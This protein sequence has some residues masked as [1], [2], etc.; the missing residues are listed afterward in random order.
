MAVDSGYGTVAIPLDDVVHALGSFDFTR[1][2]GAIKRLSVE[3][4]CYDVPL[5]PRGTVKMVDRSAV[6]TLLEDEG[7][8]A[9]RAFVDWLDTEFPQPTPLSEDDLLMKEARVVA[10]LMIDDGAT[11]DLVVEDLQIPS[12]RARAVAARATILYDQMHAK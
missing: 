2:W 11:A 9:A 4:A 12:K 5:L 8:P 6:V 10:C 7:T 1:Y 3:Y